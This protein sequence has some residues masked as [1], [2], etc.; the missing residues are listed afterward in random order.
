MYSSRLD[1]FLKQNSAACLTA[2][3]SMV[4]ESEPVI[5]HHNGRLRV[6]FSGSQALQNRLFRP[7]GT[8]TAADQD[9]E[10]FVAYT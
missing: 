1:G 5:N 9:G 2:S 6:A 3:S 4:P 8:N 10:F 7:P